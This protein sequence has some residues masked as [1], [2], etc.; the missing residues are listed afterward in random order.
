MKKAQIFLLYFWSKI[1]RTVLDFKLLYTYF[2][3]INLP[4]QPISYA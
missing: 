1:F 4:N 2:K 3:Y